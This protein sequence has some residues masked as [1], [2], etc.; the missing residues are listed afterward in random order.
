VTASAPPRRTTEAAAARGFTLI[1][2]MAVMALL[3][4]LLLFIPPNLDSFGDRS[5]LESAANSVSSLLTAA[6][7][8]AIIDGHE[9][10]VQ[11]ELAGDT[12][13]RE[14]TGRMRLVVSARKRDT[15]HG[16]EPEGTRRS[17]LEEDPEEPEEEWLET[18]WRTL[19][20]GVQLKGY[21][22]ESGQWVRSNPG[23]AP[24]EISFLADG[25]VRPAHAVRLVSLDVGS[26]D[27]RTMTVRVN[28]LT[29]AA[30]VVG[31]EADLPKGRDP[32]EFR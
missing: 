29:S 28:A 16:L 13:D 18:E 14:K 2:V 26:E 7:E 8:I 11:Y 27:H 12:K 3:G 10:L 21:S 6:R 9:T 22:E 4:I 20:K 23:S 25:T 32:N 31:G 17:W 5:R 19:P 24:I 1:E 15:P 30:E